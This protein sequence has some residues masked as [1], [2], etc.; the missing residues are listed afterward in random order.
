MPVILRIHLPTE[1]KPRPIAKRNEVVV[2]LFST[3]FHDG[4]Y[5]QNS[6]PAGTVFSIL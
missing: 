6:F 2:Q 5:L 4:T 1:T 3:V